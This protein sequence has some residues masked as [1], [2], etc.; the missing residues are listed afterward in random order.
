MNKKVVTILA[1]S[2]LF[3]SVVSAASVW[4]T[5]KGNS[6]VKITNNGKPI[7]ISDVPA[8]SYNGNT[9]IPLYLLKQ[10]GLNYHVDTKKQT[11]NINSSSSKETTSLKSLSATFKSRGINSIGYVTAGDYSTLSFNYDYKMF[12]QDEKI[13][14]KL[15]DDIMKASLGIDANFVEIVD[16]NQGKM[17]MPSSHIRSYYEGRISEEELFESMDVE[18]LEEYLE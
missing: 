14:N 17:I 9:M 5:Y 10:F 1:S 11:V 4:G 15:F 3:C 16:P 2:F 18:G 8:I 6:I 13:F 7:K 12:E